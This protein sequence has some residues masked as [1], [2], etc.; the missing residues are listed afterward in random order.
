MSVIAPPVPERAARAQPTAEARRARRRWKLALKA[1]GWTTAV[2]A[3]VTAVGF[4]LYTRREDVRGARQAARQE[5]EMM[6]QPREKVE[7]V[8]YVAQR[9]W[10]DYF[11]ETHGVLAATDR[12]LLFVGV[13]PRE[14]ITP[15]RGPQ[16]FEQ[17][18]FP[19][20]RPLVAERGRVFLG[21]SR[22][23]VLLAG[24]EKETFAVDR[25]DEPVIDS[26]LGTVA[27]VQ[28]ALREQAERERRAQLYT[29]WIASQPLYHRVV[30]GEALIS[31]AL[32]YGTTPELL[33]EWNGLRNDVVKA[34][35]RL[36]VK[37]R[38]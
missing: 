23:V 9:R 11:R 6:L 37:P 12:R 15:E 29:A 38:T 32:R 22:G 10:W 31:I 20:D 2:V 5:L 21:T 1:A 26:V 7:H 19:Y 27:H 17:K 24:G 16:V 34:G 28:L 36:L 35:Q 8:A 30:R 18:A 4:F 3:G 14:I 25:S 13:P 33:K